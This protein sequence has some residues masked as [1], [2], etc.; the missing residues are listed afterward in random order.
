[1]SRENRLR[2]LVEVDCKTEDLW[3]LVLAFRKWAPYVT[4][5]TSATHLAHYAAESSQNVLSWDSF[6]V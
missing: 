4:S 6:T 1:M 3:V 2:R 5:A